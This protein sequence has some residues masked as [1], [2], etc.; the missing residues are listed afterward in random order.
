[1]RSWPIACFVLFSTAFQR[2]CRT[3]YRLLR[4]IVP[5]REWLINL[6]HPD[7]IEVA[8]SHKLLNEGHFRAAEGVCRDGLMVVPSSIKL[9][10]N[11]AAAV[12]KQGR[13][14]AALAIM[15]EALGISPDNKILLWNREQIAT[16]NVLHGRIVEWNGTYSEFPIIEMTEF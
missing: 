5:G 13:Q 12:A 15:D 2:L 16:N 6:L 10:A 3:A 1:M 11:L 7:D 9:L 14:E 4:R 8:I